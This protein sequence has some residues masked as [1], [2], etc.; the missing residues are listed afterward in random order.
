MPN[1][2]LHLLPASLFPD[3]RQVLNGKSAADHRRKRAPFLAQRVLLHRALMRILC[4]SIPFDI[5]F[6]SL[7]VF[8]QPSC[9][10]R[11]PRDLA[12]RAGVQQLLGGQYAQNASLRRLHACFLFFASISASSLLF[13]N[14][15]AQPSFPL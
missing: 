2:S 15:A 14:F 6:V 10:P 4:A 3:R 7:P 1:G 13:E 12:S 11:S 8:N 9:V 5:P